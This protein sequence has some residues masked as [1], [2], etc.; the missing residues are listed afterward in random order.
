MK[1]ASHTTKSHSGSLRLIPGL[2]LVDL[3]KAG[4]SES[5]AD[6]LEGEF[7]IFATRMHEGLLAA[8]LAVG[9]EVFSEVIEAEV[10]Q[11]AGHKGRHDPGRV[12][13][14]H[15]TDPSKVPLGG[16]MID[17]KKP[18]VRATDGSGEITLQTWEALA[19]KEL[20]DRHTLISVLTGVSTRNYASVL[21]PVGAEL[22]A[23]ESTRVVYEG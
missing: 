1:K 20:L 8:A 9:L 15:G 18:R 7:E 3:G 22:E 16:R 21:E 17:F 13:V 12:A 14:R 23:V 2:G 6:K 4:L 10:T 19:S 11:V 5:L